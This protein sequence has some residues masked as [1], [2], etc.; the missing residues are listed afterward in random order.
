MNNQKS[1]FIDPTD[2]ALLLIDHQ[3]G[4]FQTVKD[5]DVPTLRRNVKALA[6]LA[7]IAKIPVITTASV[8]EGPNG[9]LI[10]EVTNLPNSTHIQR[11]GEINA[12]DTPDFV[13]TIEATG[14][15][16]LIIAGTWSSVCMAFP[17]LSALEA[18]YT[19]YNIVDASGTVS[20]VAA[21]ITLARVVQAGAIPVD[22]VAL[23]S[24]I[25]KTWNRPDAAEFAALYSEL[26]PN[27]RL[28]IESFERAYEE[29]QKTE[30]K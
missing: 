2:A 13:K 17:T 9:P 4:L 7:E 14:R 8:P 25:Q 11:N 5:L 6:K 28:V 29:G 27:Y 15:K 3:S 12:W 10:P 30:N 24:E 20:N 19:V 26:V 16:T 1:T 18:G 23:V 22:T 21:D